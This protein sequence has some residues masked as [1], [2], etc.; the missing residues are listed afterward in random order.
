M[1]LQSVKY[2]NC[3]SWFRTEFIPNNPRSII[4]YTLE[5]GEAEGKYENG[6]WIQY[7]WNCE[8]E[9]L[10]WREMPRYDDGKISLQQ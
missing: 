10:Y 3:D 6:K 1:K 5:G 7:R 4:L 9:P 2:E 8:V